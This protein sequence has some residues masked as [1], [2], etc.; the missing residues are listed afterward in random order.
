MLLE[1]FVKQHIGEEAPILSKDKD[2]LYYQEESIILSKG[3]ITCD[4]TGISVLGEI[5]VEDAAQMYEAG[6]PGAMVDVE[7]VLR[8]NGILAQEDEINPHIFMKFVTFHELGHWNQRNNTSLKNSTMQKTLCNQC[9][10]LW[11]QIKNKM[12]A[13]QR[14]NQFKENNFVFIQGDRQKKV[15]EEMKQEINALLREYSQ[16]YRTIPTEKDADTYALSRMK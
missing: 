12:E 14:I 6:A 3:P 5:T 16:L 8:K 4:Q 15:L 7:E 13:F 1:T 10:Q 11:E 2:Q 9:N